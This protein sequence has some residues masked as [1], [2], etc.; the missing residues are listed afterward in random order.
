MIVCGK[1]VEGVIVVDV[2][3]VVNVVGCCVGVCC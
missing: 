1:V 2:I 3:I